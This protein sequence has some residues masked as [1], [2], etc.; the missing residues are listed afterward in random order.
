MK[1]FV[2]AETGYM[3]VECRFFCI[4]TPLPTL[5]TRMRYLITFHKY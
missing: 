3:R 1:T 4:W 2:Q 5:C